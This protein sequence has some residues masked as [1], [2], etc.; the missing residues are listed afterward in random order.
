MELVVVNK[1]LSWFVLG[2]DDSRWGCSIVYKKIGGGGQK[3]KNAATYQPVST[4]VPKKAD[5]VLDPKGFCLTGIELQALFG[6]DHTAYILPGE[7]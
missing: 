3:I 2:G 7:L 4:K 5:N 1:E 6:G